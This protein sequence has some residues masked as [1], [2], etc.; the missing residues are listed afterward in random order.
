MLH[1][2]APLLCV[3]LRLLTDNKN[4]TFWNRNLWIFSPSFFQDIILTKHLIIYVYM[5]FF[6]FNRV[7]T[8]SNDTLNKISAGIAWI[9]EN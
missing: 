2:V 1:S 4:R 9:L 3:V 7:A 8:G 6:N 5:T